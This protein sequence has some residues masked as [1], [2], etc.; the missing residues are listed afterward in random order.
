MDHIS[1]TL[2]TVRKFHGV[3]LNMAIRV[4]GHV[5]PTVVDIDILITEG[6]ETQILY[7]TNGAVND[8]GVDIAM[9]SVPGIPTHLWCLSKI[10]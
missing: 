10:I 2:H 9:E 8:S 5:L 7:L 4:S 6:I 3:S 1:N